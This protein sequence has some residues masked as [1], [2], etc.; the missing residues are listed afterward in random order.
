MFTIKT[1]APYFKGSDIIQNLPE[2]VIFGWIGFD[3]QYVH[4]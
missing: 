3:Q 4:P 1:D 2:V